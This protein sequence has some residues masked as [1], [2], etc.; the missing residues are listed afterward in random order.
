M[1]PRSRVELLTRGFS[2]RPEDLVELLLDQLIAL[3]QTAAN[4]KLALGSNGH[5]SEKTHEVVEFLKHRG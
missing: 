3:G 5:S 1:V 4:L 2:V